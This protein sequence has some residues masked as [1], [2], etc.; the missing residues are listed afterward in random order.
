MP[1]RRSARSMGAYL[2]HGRTRS[3]AGPPRCTSRWRR[4]ASD[5]AFA[6]EPF[7]ADDLAALSADAVGAGAARAPDAG[8]SRQPAR[9]DGRAPSAARRRRRQ[10]GDCSRRAM[11]CSS[12]SD[13][14]RASS[15]SASKIRVH[16]DYHLGQVLWAEGDFY[17]LDFEGEPARPLARAPPEAVAAE[18]RRRHAALVQLRRLRGALRLHARRGRPSSRGSSRGRASGRRGRRRRSCSGYFDDRRRRAVPAGRAR[19]SATRC[20][21]SSCSTRRSTS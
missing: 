17:I 12:G 20:C 8:R 15:S 21:G 3:D 5:P 11:R 18:G 13:R 10:R 9:R 6:P 4:D 19:R 14:R 1:P 2:G 16:G 7:D